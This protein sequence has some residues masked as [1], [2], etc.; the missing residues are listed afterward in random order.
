MATPWRFFRNVHIPAG[1]EIGPGL[2]MVH[3]QSILVLPGSKIG[4]GCSI[5]HEVTLGT[6]HE[7]GA[8]T[9]GDNVMLFAGSKVLGGIEVGNDVQVGANAVVTKN[10]PEGATVAAPPSRAIPKA[11]AKVVRR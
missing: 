3:A 6:G 8:P 7:P 4:S 5:Y 10:V 1:A 11:I 2:R 9:V